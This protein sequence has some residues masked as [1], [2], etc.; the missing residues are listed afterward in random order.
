[1]DTE[2]Y[3]YENPDQKPELKELGNDE[4][5]PIGQCSCSCCGS[6]MK[7]N[8]LPGRRSQFGEYDKIRPNAQDFV[9]LT[10]H[11]KFLCDRRI[12][13]YVLSVRSWQLLDI[14]NFAR[15]HWNRLMIDNQLSIHDGDRNMI[16]GLVKRY[17]RGHLSESPSKGQWQADFISD[18]G[19]NMIFLLHGKPGVGMLKCCRIY[20]HLT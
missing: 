11:Q 10:D 17:L 9:G 12:Y 14:A 2:G 13:A 1:M 19:D 6:Y 4:I 7:I 5:V 20:Y 18:K 15:C 3:Y 8:N 16:K